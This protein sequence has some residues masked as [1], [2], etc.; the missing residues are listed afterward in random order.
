MKKTKIE[1]RIK[2][3]F[4]AFFEDEFSDEQTSLTVS[5]NQE[6]AQTFATTDISQKADKYFGLFKKVFS[7]LPGVLFL[8]LAVPATIMFGLSIWGLFWFAA[9]IFMVWSGIGDLKNKKHFLLPL[10][11]VFV[12]LIFSIP[13]IISP[14]SLSNYYNYFYIGIL[15]LLFIA[16]I[17]VKNYIKEN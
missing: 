13:F 16:P 1:Q 9:G 15:P 8:H 5:G 2:N 14:F 11:V 4:N 7:F 6:I 17:L 12:A 10:S 3:A